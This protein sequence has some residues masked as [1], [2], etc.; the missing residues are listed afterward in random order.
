M[1]TNFLFLDELLDRSLDAEGQET[2]FELL[3]DMIQNVS[4]LFVVSHRPELQS[5]FDKVWK[6]ERGKVIT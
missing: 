1:S 4:S 6:V 3:Q 2:T 5:M